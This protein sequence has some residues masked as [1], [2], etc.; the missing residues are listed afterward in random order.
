MSDHVMRKRLHDL[1]A[2][3]SQLLRHRAA[4]DVNALQEERLTF[5]DRMADSLANA[6]GSWRFII[7]FLVFLA[8]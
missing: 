5:G 2:D 8:L 4:V 7:G 3:V 6:A 1:E